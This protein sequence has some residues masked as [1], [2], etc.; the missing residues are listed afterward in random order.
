MLPCYASWFHYSGWIAIFWKWSIYFEWVIIS[1][2]HFLFVIVTVVGLIYYEVSFWLATSI[3]I[4]VNTAFI[5]IWNCT[6]LVFIYCIENLPAKLLVLVLCLNSMLLLLE[7]VCCYILWPIKVSQRTIILL[8]LIIRPREP[9]LLLRGR[10]RG[11]G[12]RYSRRDFQAP[13]VGDAASK[14]V[15]KAPEDGLPNL[16][17]EIWCVECGAP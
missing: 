5:S 15:P 10:P 14:S 17:A 7:C 4:D 13:V 16:R 3:S 6:S 9:L 8:S 1:M 12:N 2:I 11:V